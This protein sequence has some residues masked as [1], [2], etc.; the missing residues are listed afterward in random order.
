[1]EVDGSSIQDSIQQ[2]VTSMAGMMK[3]QDDLTSTVNNLEGNITDKVNTTLKDFQADMKKEMAT[4][5][6]KFEDVDESMRRFA[7]QL[8]DLKQRT[9]KLEASPSVASASS[10]PF[11]APGFGPSSSEAK[12]Q[13]SWFAWPAAK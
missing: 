10:G 12:P 13:A 7:K 9:S 2:L 11:S 5:T 3:K 1:M 6:K 4:V 8:D